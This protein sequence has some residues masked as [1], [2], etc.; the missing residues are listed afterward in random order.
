MSIIF[1]NLMGHNQNNRHPNLFVIFSVFF[2]YFFSTTANAI[3]EDFRLIE[4]N[5]KPWIAPGKVGSTQNN[6]ITAAQIGCDDWKFHWGNINY[7]VEDCNPEELQPNPNRPGDYLVSYTRVNS[8]LN[9]RTSLHFSVFHAL[10]CT[11]SPYTKPVDMDGDT[12]PDVCMK[13]AK[14][15]SNR[16]VVGDPIVCS[17]GESI[18]T[19]PIYSGKGTDPLE[20]NISYKS[21]LYS[22]EQEE[23]NQ[24]NSHLGQQ[25]NDNQFRTLNTIYTKGSGRIVKLT[26]GGGHSRLYVTLNGSP[27]MK[28]VGFDTKNQERYGYINLN[29]DGTLTYTTKRGDT[30]KFSAN[31][32][33][34]SKTT[35]NG[36][37]RSFSYTST[38]KLKTVTNHYGKQLTFFYNTSDELERLVAPAGEEFWFEYD[39]T[40]NLVKVIY[41]DDTP[42]TNTDNPFIQYLFEDARFPKSMTAKIN[43]KGIR[44]ATWS[45]DEFGRAIDN[46]LAGGVERVELDYS[47]ENQTKVKTFISDNLSNEKI[48]HFT[49]DLE[50]RRLLTKLEQLACTD[51]VTGDYVYEYNAAGNQTKATSP[52]GKVNTYEYNSSA[53]QTKKILAEGT[54]EAQQVTTNWTNNRPTTITEGNLKTVIGYKTNGDIYYKQLNDLTTGKYRITIYQFYPQGKL[55]S[56]NGPI[57]GSSDTTNYY[58][59]SNG[60][61]SKVRNALGHETLFTDYDASGRV[62]KVTD[63]NGVV[64]TLT[65]IPRGW[66]K[67]STTHGAVTQYDY[68]PTGS[69]KSV[70]S[71]TGQ[72][73]NYEYDD[74]ERLT[75][76]TDSQGNRIEYTRDLMGN[77]TET[78]TKDS[79]GVLKRSQ[80]SVFNALGQLTK[81]LGNNGQSNELTYD[82]DGNPVTDKN[83]LNNQTTSSF[84]ALNR[85]KKIVDPDN[86]ETQFGYDQ[87]NQITNVTDAEGQSTQY[88]YNAFGDLTKLISKDTGT[89]TFTYDKAGNRLTKTD[90]RGVT[91]T[92]TYD[93][94]NRAKTQSYSDSTE[95]IV[96][97]Y[98]ETANGNKGIGRLTSVT[99]QS[100]STHYVYNSFGQV[101]KETRVIDGK[102]YVTEYHFD[103]QG[104]MTGVTY[105]GGRKLTYTFDA[106]G[107]VNGLNSTLNNQTK[108]LASNIAYLPFGPMTHLTFGNGKMLT[109][110]FDL[111]YRLTS[112]TV[113]GI[114]EKSYTYDLT[115]NITGIVN[116]LD[117]GK[118]QTLTYDKLSRLLT[119]NGGYGDISF[120][121][122]KV[123]NRKTKTDNNQTGTYAYAADSHRLTEVTGNQAKSFTNDAMGNTLT[124]GD[125]TFTYNQHGRMKTA[126]KTGMNANYVYNFKGERSI[127][128]VNGNTNHFIYSLDGQLIAEANSQGQIQ[129]EYIYLNGQRLAT[130]DNNQ[131]YYVHTNHLDTP[132]AITNETDTI[133]WQ[134]HYTPFGKAI[135]TTNNLNQSIRFPGQYLDDETGLH[136]NYFRDYDPEIG[137]YIQSDPIGLNGGI[138]TYGYVGG[139]PINRI[140]P[141]GLSWLNPRAVFQFGRMIGNAQAAYLAAQRE[142]DSQARHRACSAGITA[143]CLPDFPNQFN[144][145]SDDNVIPFPSTNETDTINSPA[146]PD[147]CESAC[148]RRYQEQLRNCNSDGCSDN[149]QRLQCIE[150][151]KRTWNSCIARCRANKQ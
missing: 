89:T 151:A 24:L 95:N 36:I 139:N 140:D 8:F 19:T 82:A 116:S 88:E 145:G 84:D 49:T 90:A 131:L 47:V 133:Q 33:I 11:S 29:G 107:R 35:K 77:I 149:D 97:T 75:A 103:N 76:V 31:G 70:T 137:R 12:K 96:Y 86:G 87:H 52:T 102:N 74:G 9:I 115:N 43:E 83:A 114:D 128:Q 2:L 101:T 141:E 121:Y 51:C 105:P 109:Q 15:E 73:I 59:D 150:F 110:G 136:Y 78:K 126:S 63:A 142:A 13:P 144:E 118:N 1:H 129:K 21:P 17:T 92:F 60:N 30:Q 120:T 27:I 99:D 130:V 85:I 79:N 7:E 10:E 62:G 61:I 18:Q 65:Y 134:A 124:Q 138:N 91:V 108:T 147:A 39:N 64:T 58:Y 42:S 66:L 127:K 40:G 132:V 122:D 4:E 81:N 71:P 125:L 6:A 104:Q 23:Y 32:K 34:L 57:S 67:T 20:Y 117:N 106:L 54:A 22:D 46:E 135:V 111:D 80:Q 50:G 16:S 5:Y 44:F 56:I 41:P 53:L 143:A 55:K 38:G 100:G 37:N 28:T 69:L 45:Y 113:S 26:W 14:C 98:D 68:F 119:A 146:L 148:N 72:V 112:K 93:A 25:L 94:L 3:G 123:G 48:Y